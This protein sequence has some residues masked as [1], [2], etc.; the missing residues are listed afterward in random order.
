VLSTS[1]WV[2]SQIS[3]VTPLKSPN[4]SYSKSHQLSLTIVYYGW[5]KRVFTGR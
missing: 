1:L 5:D 4:S 2:Y 3:W